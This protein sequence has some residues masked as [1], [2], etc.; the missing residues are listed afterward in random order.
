MRAGTTHFFL[1][2]LLF[3][4]MHRFW[5]YRTGVA[6]QTVSV[7]T[8]QIMHVCPLC[9][10]VLFVVLLT[11]CPHPH[12]SVRHASPIP[13]HANWASAGGGVPSTRVSLSTAI[14]KDFFFSWHFQLCDSLCTCYL[15]LLKDCADV[16]SGKRPCTHQ[17]VTQHVWMGSCSAVFQFGSES[18]PL[19]DRCSLSPVCTRPLPPLYLSIVATYPNRASEHTHIIPICPVTQSKIQVYKRA[20]NFTSHSLTCVCYIRAIYSANQRQLISLFQIMFL[21]TEKLYKQTPAS[22]QL[23]DSCDIWPITIDGIYNISDKHLCWY[24]KN[25]NPQCKH[26]KTALK[27]MTPS[28]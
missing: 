7:W 27:K 1:F 14:N 12:L 6:V 4:I 26:Y 15:K 20:A 21:C 8:E 28:T 25:N 16:P 18:S 9:V 13:Q 2:V 5:K 17:R 23:Y 3:P 24:N 11:F 19:N 10:W 22:N